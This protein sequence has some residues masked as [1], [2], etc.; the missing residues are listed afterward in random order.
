MEAVLTNNIKVFNTR[1]KY[2]ERAFYYL[3]M[4]AELLTLFYITIKDIKQINSNKTAVLLNRTNTKYL[5]DGLK[6]KETLLNE[7]TK[8]T[9]LKVEIDNKFKISRET[10]S[11]DLLE[12]NTIYYIKYI[13]QVKQEKRTIYIMYL[14]EENRDAIYLKQY[15]N[16]PPEYKAFK[17]NYY[18]E[19]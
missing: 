5:K 18:V 3:T 14:L 6:E 1:N 12:E 4:D 2:K 7:K 19:E 16:D 17:S 11:V 13:K 10:A 15:E 9:I 8:E